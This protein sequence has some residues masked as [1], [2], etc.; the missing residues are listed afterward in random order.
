MMWPSNLGNGRFVILE[1]IL[2]RQIFASN[3]RNV[4]HLLLGKIN[5]LFRFLLI[6][7]IEIVM[8]LIYK[9]MPSRNTNNSNL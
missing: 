9:S 1:K 6:G 3:L 4:E 8:I 2:R 7:Q 5:F